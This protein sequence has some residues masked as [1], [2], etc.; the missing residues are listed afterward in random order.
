MCL[1]TS[2]GAR[3]PVE[4]LTKSHLFE[5]KGGPVI[6]QMLHNELNPSFITSASKHGP[7]LV[8]EA[9]HSASHHFSHLLHVQLLWYSE[10][11]YHNQ[12][13]IYLNHIYKRNI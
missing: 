6:F 3:V 12:N 2:G 9:G 10:V 8:A 13:S 4:M 1:A 11:R 5:S 7:V